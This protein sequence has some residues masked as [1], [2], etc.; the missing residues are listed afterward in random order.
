MPPELQQRIENAYMVYRAWEFNAQG[1]TGAEYGCDIEAVVTSGA[2]GIDDE[3]MISLPQLR[4]IVSFGVGT[5]KINIPLATLRGI[6]VSNTPG[7]LD[8]CVADAA[9]ALLMDLARGISAA[10]RFVR[11]GKWRDQAF[12]LQTRLR[13]KVCGIVGLGN[14]GRGIAVRA[15]A[16]GMHIAYCGRSRQAG[17]PYAYYSTVESLAKA[18]DFLVLAV[19]GGEETKHLVDSK[20]LNALGCTGFLINVSRG[21]VVDQDALIAALSNETIA[22]AGLDVFDNEPQVPEALLLLET[23][24]LTP[25]LASATHETRAAMS[26]LVWRNLNG[27][28]TTRTLPTAV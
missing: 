21:S 13:G 19:P 16:F 28:F 27:F 22:G 15:S 5:D 14:I 1:V 23:V 17:V 7:V 25:H 2:L 9:F 18:A 26:D 12:P 24:V 3:L 8:N 4:L 10:D 11:R 20:V 6:Q